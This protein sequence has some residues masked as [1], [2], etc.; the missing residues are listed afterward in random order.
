MKQ[1]DTTFKR[2]RT[3][4][5]QPAILVVGVNYSGLLFLDAVY[6]CSYYVVIAFDEEC[7]RYRHEVERNFN[8]A[9]FDKP[10]SYGTYSLLN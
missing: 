6:W 5:A 9:P 8:D 7:R 4:I 1:V 2:T 3:L 10:F